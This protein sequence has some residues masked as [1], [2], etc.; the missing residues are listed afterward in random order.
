MK[1]RMKPEAGQTVDIGH[2]EY[3]RVFNRADQP[4][5]VDDEE[6]ALLIGT[7]MFEIVEPRVQPEVATQKTSGKP[8]RKEVKE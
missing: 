2:G 4:F 8:G 5:K 6:A 3:S 1:L 7:G